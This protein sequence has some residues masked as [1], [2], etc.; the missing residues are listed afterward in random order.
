L[1]KGNVFFLNPSVGKK[2]KKGKFGQGVKVAAGRFI[3]Q[4]F[5]KKGRA[6][7]GKDKKTKKKV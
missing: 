7:K 1:K 3:V 4:N 5:N 6:E 2:R